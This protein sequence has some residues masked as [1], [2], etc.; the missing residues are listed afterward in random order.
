VAQIETRITDLG[1]NGK[2]IRLDVMRNIQDAVSNEIKRGAKTIIA[3]GND[4]T[5]N[6]VVNAILRT[7]INTGLGANLPLGIIPIG[8]KNNLIAPI[9]GITDAE[10]ACDVLSARRVE[11]LDIG[12]AN[13]N[14]FLS[15][16]SITSKNTTLEIDQ[17]YSVE[18]IDPGL[19]NI[20]NLPPAYAIPPTQKDFL[21]NNQP[22]PGD[23][24]LDLYI[25]TKPKKSLIKS[26]PPPSTSYFS[27]D[28]L[29]I[30]NNKEPITL[31][32]SLKIQTPAQIS[33]LKN[34]LN[35]IVGKDR[36][37]V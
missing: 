11:K 33:V 16:A 9:L 36:G 8:D 20:F 18:I 35:I 24:K 37:F 23:G 10:D 17:N 6:R 13:Q 29:T 19:I 31:D 7:E 3:V 26:K 32:N 28:K 22:F 15:Q 21:K 2:I 27:L 30:I 4:I 14:Y 1:L 12:Q 34:K 5:I 25:N